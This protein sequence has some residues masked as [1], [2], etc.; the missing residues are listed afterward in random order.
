MLSLHTKD[1]TFHI[2]FIYITSKLGAILLAME[3]Q[4]DKPKSKF[5]VP[6]S[7]IPPPESNPKLDLPQIGT[8]LSIVKLRVSYW[9][10]FKTE[11]IY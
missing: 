7:Q 8:R 5:Q 10:W 4:T 11:Q 2:A 6:N 1:V 3:I 9:T